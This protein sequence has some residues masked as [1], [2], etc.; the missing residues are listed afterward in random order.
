MLKQLNVMGVSTIFLNGT[1]TAT[2]VNST[3][4]LQIGEYSAYSVHVPPIL[5]SISGCSFEEVFWFAFFPTIEILLTIYCTSMVKLVLLTIEQ[6][7][8]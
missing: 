8:R 1:L 6:S 4:L 3:Y 5:H 2:K 7:T